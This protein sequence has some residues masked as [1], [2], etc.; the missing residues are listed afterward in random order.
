MGWDTRLKAPRLSSS[1]V[2]RI[3]A[4]VVAS[5][6]LTALGSFIFSNLAARSAFG[7]YVTRFASVRRQHLVALLEEYYRTRGSWAGV[8]VLLDAASR[9]GGRGLGMGRGPGF[10]MRMGEFERVMLLD[11]SGSVISDTAG[12]PPGTVV[13]FQAWEVTPVRSGSTIVGLLLLGVPEE[14]EAS[15]ALYTEFIRSVTAGTLYSVLG[16]AALALVLSYYIAERTVKPVR[17]LT[18]AV[19]E[20]AR[21]NLTT[22]VKAEGNDEIARLAQAFNTMSSALEV[23]EKKRKDL[24]ADVAHE[25]RT[26]LTVLKSN[27]EGIKDGVIESTPEL[28]ETLSGEVERLSRLVS[29]LHVLAL[30]DSGKLDLHMGIVDC[31]R[32]LTHAREAFGA[33][34]ATKSI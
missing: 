13:K 12:T 15:V 10:G 7:S 32:L 1:L 6:M 20:V 25:L 3:L 33:T 18:A 24:V 21:G 31:E 4:V 26:P 2:T 30:A 5:V 14:R 22:R 16:A 34:A 29:D 28:M 23:A 11:P 27:F 19:A 8:E 9:M 17:E